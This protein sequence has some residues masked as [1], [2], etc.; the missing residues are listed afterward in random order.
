MESGDPADFVENAKALTEIFGGWPSFHDAEVVQVRL[1]RSGPGGP[2][3][4]ARIHVFER[5]DQVT[6][7]GYYVLVNHTLV[8]LRFTDVSGCRMEGF[9][10]QNVLSELVLESCS[11]EP[12]PRV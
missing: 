12:S 5:T 11:Q 7:T 6:P 1:D 9:N 4:E 8:T 2:A 10:H 3:V